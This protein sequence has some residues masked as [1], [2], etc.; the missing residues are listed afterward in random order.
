MVGMQASDSSVQDDEND[1]RR[2]GGVVEVGLPVLKAAG[3]VE[4]D[5]EMKRKKQY[6]DREWQEF[7][8]RNSVFI[9]PSNSEFLIYRWVMA[10]KT[11]PSRTS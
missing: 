4:R 5:T 3:H 8:E 10:T 6:T 7:I 1:R 9:Y 2:H 11:G